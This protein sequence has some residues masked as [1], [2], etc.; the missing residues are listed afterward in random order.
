MSCHLDPDTFSDFVEYALLSRLS[1]RDNQV[2][3]WVR[4][5][6]AKA[7]WTLVPPNGLPRDGQLRII[8]RSENAKLDGRSI[9]Q[10]AKPDW[11]KKLN[12]KDCY[13]KPVSFL[14]V[15]D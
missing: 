13:A 2:I 6:E 3:L 5:K 10:D 1:F 11:A 8:G 12:R 4:R 15:T 14:A 9:V 7:Q